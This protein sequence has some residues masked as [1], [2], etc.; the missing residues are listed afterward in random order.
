M[1][2]KICQQSDSPLRRRQIYV[3]KTPTTFSPPNDA[4]NPEKLHQSLPGYKPTPL[5][6]LD[7]LANELGVKAVL[8]KDESNRLGLPSFKLVGAAWGMFRAVAEKVG[9]NHDSGV[10]AVS[11]AAQD[12]HIQIF[13]A[14]KGN[15]GRSVAW[16]ARYLGLPAT[17]CVPISM[18]E[19]TRDRISSEGAKV[20]IVNSDYDAAVKAATSAA[21]LCNGVLVQDTAFDGYQDIPAWIIQGYATIFNEIDNQSATLNLQPTAIVAPC[22]VGSITEAAVNYAK[23]GGRNMQVIGLEPDTAACLYESLQAGESVSVKTSHTI[24]NGMDCGTLST[25]SWPV[26]RDNIDLS[27]TVSDY[28]SHCAVRYL[29]ACGMN[30]GPC[31]AAGVAALRRLHEEGRLD[32]DAVIVLLCTEGFRPY[33]IPHDVS[34]KDSIS[35]TQILTQITSASRGQDAGES[36]VADFI[37]SWLQHRDIEVHRIEATDGRSS[38]V[39]I[40][41]GTGGGKTIMLNDRADHVA[42]EKGEIESVKVRGGLVDSRVATAL[43]SLADAT[44]ASHALEEDLVLAIMTHG[45]SHE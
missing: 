17:I 20:I 44:S 3:R 26:L 7:G 28:E 34:C 23:G 27:L 41:R 36:M 22:G 31:G 39:G 25:T 38:V 8:I 6:S 4:P 2:R 9:L 10:E 11:S 1:A 30:A 24:M 32:K 12:Q 43:L 15:H 45:E 13:A 16:M 40:V 29:A 33:R 21:R 37:T 18:D 19:Y 42:A 5:I 35:L 14:T